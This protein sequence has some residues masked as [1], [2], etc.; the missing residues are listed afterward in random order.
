TGRSRTGQHALAHALL[1]LLLQLA[2]GDGEKQDPR[3]RSPIRCFVRIK[4][5]IDARLAAATNHR[6]CESCHGYGCLTRPR[7]VVRS[8]YYRRRPH[9]EGFGKGVVH[10]DAID[11]QLRHGMVSKGSGRPI[12]ASATV[13]KSGESP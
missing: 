1:Q 3:T 7:R 12:A 6:G 10:T 9:S 11:D 8:D 4:H 13:M 2:S 5:T